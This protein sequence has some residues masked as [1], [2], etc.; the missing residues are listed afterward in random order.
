MKSF[1]LLT[2]L[3]S[4]VAIAEEKAA[5]I[6]VAD[7]NYQWSIIVDNCPIDKSKKA[8]ILSRPTLPKDKVLV[9]QGKKTFRCDVKEIN[10]VVA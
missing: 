3:L 10:I 5:T 1:T 8:I 7:N 9:R 4:T 2:M 6:Q